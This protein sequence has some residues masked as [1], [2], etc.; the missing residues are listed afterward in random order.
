MASNAPTA[1]TLPRAGRNEFLDLIQDLDVIVWEMDVASFT[2]TFVSGRAE[3]ILGYP[4]RR[5]I[6]EPTFW[7]DVLVHP[8]DRTWVTE[9]CLAETGEARDHSLEYRAVHA[10]GHVVW[11][12]DSAR[13]ICGEDGTARL[14]RGVMMDITQERQALD[15]LAEREAQL[16]ESQAIAGIGSWQ[17]DV[18]SNRITWSHQQFRL[19][20]REPLPHV[21]FEWFFSHVHPDDQPWLGARMERVLVSGESFEFP[22][23]IVRPDGEVRWLY[24]RGHMELSADGRPLRM[25]G[26]SHDITD[27]KLTE[28]ELRASEES[29]RAI[30]NCSND[31]IF[32]HDIETG[33]ILDAN[34]VAC[35]LSGASREEL[36]TRG[37]E[38]IG[39]GPPPFT[40]ERAL[41]YIGRAAAGEPQRFEWCALHPQTGERMWVE[42]S[43]QRVTIRGED[44]LL[45]IAR[46]IRERKRAEQALIASEEAYRTI[47]HSA[48]VG[49][50]VHD[51][52]S[53]EILECNQ[54]AC[55]IYGY[56]VEEQR[57]IGVQGLA[58][59]VPPH[60]V[61]NQPALARRAL[62]GE[63]QRFEFLG[64][65][66]DGSDVW[67]EVSI[68][69]VE[70]GG[71]R[72]FLV[73]SRDIG[74]QKRAEE[75][76]RRSHEDLEQRV[77]ERTA[78]LE[79]ANRAL[80][81]E[82]AERKAAEQRVKEREEHF[83]MLI[84]NAHDITSIIDAE[85][86]ML[87]TTPAFTRI[88]GYGTEE[89]LG[90]SIFDYYHP[91]DIERDLPLVR[92]LIDNPGSK[93]RSEHRIRHKHGGYRYL[94]AF[95]QTV[96]PHTADQGIVVNIRDITEQKRAEEALR[97][98]EE[99]FRRLI[100]NS[101]DYVMIADR[102]AALTYVG[103][104]AERILGFA[105]EEM[106]GK[107]PP[108]LIHPDDVPHVLE[109][110]EYLY[111]HPGE[112]VTSVFRIRH[113]DG[114]WRV[115]ESVGRTLLP[116]SPDQ[117]LVANSRDITERTR[118]EAKLRAAME[119]AERANRAK[120]EF[121]S[122][123]SHELRTPMNSILGFAQV[124]E[125]AGLLPRH[126]RCV[127][128]IL[129][130]GRHLLQLINEVL[131]I[132]RIEA[133]RQ[134]LSLEPVRLGSVLQEAIGLARPMAAQARLELE[135]AGLQHDG[136]YVWADR[137][138]LSQVLLNLLSNAIKYNRAGGRVRLSCAEAP[139]TGDG[140]TRIW[141]RVEDTGRG[142]P[143][144]RQEELFTPFA[145]L[146]AEM[147][148]VEGTGL[149]LALSQR[150][151]EAMGGSLVLERSSGEGS[152]FRIE[153]RVTLS[154]LDRVE[155][156]DTSPRSTGK[157][158]HHPATLLYIEDNLANLSLVETILWER[159][160]WRTVSALQ[161]QIG[162]EL[163]REH[164][165]D[166][167]L[168]D[169]HLPDIHGDEV[170]RRLREDER[171]ARI[172]V[173]VISADATR[174]AI[175]RLMEAGAA[176]FLTKPLEVG[177]FLETLERLLPGHRG[178]DD[179]TRAG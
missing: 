120:S 54:T 76:L 15:S 122:R 125:S 172:P 170:L 45:A 101:S 140:V 66:K 7:Q 112:V 67:S 138:R 85:G 88:L 116:D 129:K 107:R 10:G 80:E 92:H 143:A 137:Q 110:V 150:L 179:T 174:A 139:D 63:L 18:P 42:V 37:V 77:A 166:L 57:A 159:P 144:D 145:R 3:H 62:A 164:L 178:G 171:T 102:N 38:I 126:E 69:V 53:L 100:E 47:F 148:E 55:E 52:E 119:E 36:L 22:Y 121:L 11:L 131:E 151:A 14:L 141:V 87:Y 167:I 86:R 70:I 1:A 177:E 91:E 12:R 173:L 152:V 28:D 161:G 103:P 99:H 65:H 82:V 160:K 24:A 162:V 72:R 124:L 94:E 73:T 78:A 96:S 158:P 133:G 105:P 34:R 113:R 157:V 48:G 104:S 26:T 81:A 149:G 44:R 134:N 61:V 39:S 16:A 51:V 106:L 123:M 41:E 30:F 9:L 155:E 98:S 74:E 49:I 114:N 130:A 43:L 89:L 31:A 163:A 20:G 93:V 147:G 21:T 8:D 58:S 135:Y 40:E 154:P 176:A 84:E 27:R 68:H 59:G 142:I 13:V 4:A 165:P 146:G 79:A 118:A 156:G 29:Y 136:S 128:H 25:V 56:S 23:R 175:Q 169:L 109:D 64:R 60:G 19:H 97:Q 50:W 71:V 75:A 115:F 153:L 83:R 2:F 111:S 32:I 90:Q 46:D 127:Q 5:W 95:G 117:V 33:A 168:L 132:A 6:E 17:W 108:E 35:E